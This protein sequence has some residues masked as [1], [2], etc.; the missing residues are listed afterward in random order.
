MRWPLQNT[1]NNTSNTMCFSNRQ[2][3]Q[4]HIKLPAVAFSSFISCERLESLLP[5]LA[6]SYSWF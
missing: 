5:S 6:I 4:E 2:E 1:K 3:N